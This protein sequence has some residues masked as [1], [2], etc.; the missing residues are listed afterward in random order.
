MITQAQKKIDE[1]DSS[2]KNA[3]EAAN[4]NKSL[5]SNFEKLENANSVIK[6]SLYSE[7]K[8]TNEL[9]SNIKQNEANFQSQLEAAQERIDELNRSLKASRTFSCFR[10]REV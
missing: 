3:L 5:K 9:K 8:K 1:L 6:S 10:K 4:Q 7:K 2:L